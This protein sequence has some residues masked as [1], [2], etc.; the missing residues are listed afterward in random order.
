[1]SLFD[2][3]IRKNRVNAARTQLQQ[4]KWQSEYQQQQAQTELL[5]AMQT[6]N[7]NREQLN[8]NSQNLVLAEKVFDSRRTLYTEGVTTLVEL[9]DAENELTQARNLYIQSLIHVQTGTLDV[10]KANGTLLTEFLKSL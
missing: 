6:L 7:N 9:L 1:M 8:I 2:G 3:N 4:L 5:S 10:H